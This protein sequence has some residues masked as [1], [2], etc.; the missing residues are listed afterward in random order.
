ME[1]SPR[2][3]RVTRI[4]IFKPQPGVLQLI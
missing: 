3:E 4:F 2:W 1:K